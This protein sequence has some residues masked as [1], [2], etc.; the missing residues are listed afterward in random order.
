MHRVQEGAHERN[1]PGRSRSGSLPQPVPPLLSCQED[2][3]GGQ[4]QGPAADTFEEIADEGGVGASQTRGGIRVCFSGSHDARREKTCDKE[5]RQG[6]R[7]GG[8][9][10][11]GKPSRE[12][13]GR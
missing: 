9:S 10:C 4:D 8:D 2:D 5:D 3:D 11:Y 7:T 6:V 13:E 1:R 12:E